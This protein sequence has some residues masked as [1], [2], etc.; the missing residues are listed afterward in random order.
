MRKPTW[1]VSLVEDDENDAAFV[2]ASLEMFPSLPVE[3]VRHRTLADAIGSAHEPDLLILDL[4]LPDSTGL[5]TLA[6]LGQWIPRPAT[7]VITGQKEEDVR[8]RALSLGVFR[9][10]DKNEINKV[11]LANSIL[12][13]LNSVDSSRSA[14]EVLVLNKELSRL[15]QFAYAASH[16]LREP[17]RSIRTFT[18]FFLEEYGANLDK[19]AEDY[20]S[21][22]VNSSDRLSKMIEQMLVLAQTGL[23]P[24]QPCR[25]SVREIIA[26]IKED[27]SATIAEKSADIR[28]EEFCPDVLGDDLRIRQIFGNLI[29]NA[30]TYNESSPPVV[31]IGVDEEEPAMVTFYVRDNGIGISPEYHKRIFDAFSRGNVDAKFKGSGIGLAIVR[32][33]I[34]ALNGEIRLNSAYGRGS[35]FYVRLPKWEAHWR[36][37]RAAHLK[38]A[39]V[40]FLDAA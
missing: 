15:R 7:L 2:L 8:H 39:E 23:A 19:R 12:D 25:V 3:L 32:E 21:R 18:K 36:R 17:L 28:L 4:G 13:A 14:L 10:L 40:E 33:A 27:F 34:G 6:Q 38:A 20:L 35:V 22:V 37:P 29:G 24:I 9:Y 30:L 31:N 11:L 5:E 26:E 1:D 16:D